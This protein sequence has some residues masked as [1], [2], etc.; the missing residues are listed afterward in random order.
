MLPAGGLFLRIL[1]LQQ[2]QGLLFH[3]TQAKLLAGLLEADAKAAHH[4]IH[5]REGLFLRILLLQEAQGLLFHLAQAQL[6]TGLLEA[7]AK[8]AHH[9]IDSGQIVFHCVFH[10]DPPDPSLM[11]EQGGRDN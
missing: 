9:D 1:L 11:P 4:D 7:D 2:A 6:F 5:H 10:G 8:V 3:L